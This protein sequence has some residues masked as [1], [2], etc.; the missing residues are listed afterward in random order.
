MKRIFTTIFTTVLGFY[1]NA[2]NPASTLLSTNFDGAFG[3][4]VNPTGWISANL[5]TSDVVSASAP[6]YGGS[7]S[8]AKI[9]TK[10]INSII[11]LP[12][13]IP[14]QSGILLSGT[15]IPVGATI[16]V[17]QGQPYTSRPE[18]MAY[19][20]KYAPV[21]VDSA[22]AYILLT[23]WNTSLPIAK[24]DTI[25][26][27]VDIISSGVPNWTKRTVPII[28]NTN[29]ANPDTLLVI[30]SSSSASAPQLGSVYTVDELIFYP[31]NTSSISEISNQDFG[32]SPNPSSGIVSIKNYND[33]V[34]NIQIIDLMG[35]V[36]REEKISN[37]Y[38]DIDLSYL[39]NGLYFVI[40][41]DELNRPI[42]KSKIEIIK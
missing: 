40:G 12:P 39:S 32:L 14:P 8:A 36:I 11:P 29:T 13:V 38:K 9:T 20:T 2:Q 24:R 17:K 31:A 30:F 3:G 6:G 4:N 34:K 1:A 19:W 27:A 23:K 26:L 42:N 21:G 7:P 28:Y 10:T 15:I 25:G 37:A 41:N 18:G 35:K 22:F 5:L 33:K 16:V